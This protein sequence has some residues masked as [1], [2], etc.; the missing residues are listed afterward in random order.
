MAL[1]FASHARRL[2]LAGAGAPAR[3]L[4]AQPYQARV[5]VAEFLNGVGKRV[6][7]HAAKPEDAVGSDIQR[8]IEA[9]KLRRKNRRIPCKRATRACPRAGELD[10]STKGRCVG[11]SFDRNNIIA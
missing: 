10:R 1:A 6:E 9:G 11:S 3:S 7:K 5:D 8:L 4:H 2:L